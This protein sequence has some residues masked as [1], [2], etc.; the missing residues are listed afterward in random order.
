MEKFE[1]FGFEKVIT[2][3]ILSPVESV[4]YNGRSSSL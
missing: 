1:T 3:A 2:A 4:L